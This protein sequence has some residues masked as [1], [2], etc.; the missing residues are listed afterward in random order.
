MFSSQI[1]KNIYGGEY[2]QTNI[3]LR[4]KQIKETRIN[5]TSLQRKLEETAQHC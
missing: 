5:N 3:T 2:K 1:G 4:P